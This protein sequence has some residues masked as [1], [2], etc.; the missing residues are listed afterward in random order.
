MNPT[1]RMR[2]F[3]YTF[4]FTLSPNFSQEY[5]RSVPLQ[6]HLLFAKF[7]ETRDSKIPKIAQESK[8]TDLI[9]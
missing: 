6:K 2:D 8:Q 5:P 9:L 7:Y 3:R 1:W 4:E